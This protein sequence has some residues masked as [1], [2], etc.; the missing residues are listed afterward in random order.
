VPSGFLGAAFV[1]GGYDGPGAFLGERAPTT[2]SRAQPA[3]FGT[4]CGF[5]RVCGVVWVR[6]YYPTFSL[7]IKHIFKNVDLAR[8]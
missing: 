2:E 4:Q 3:F 5:V 6:Y 1:A 7:F 8:V